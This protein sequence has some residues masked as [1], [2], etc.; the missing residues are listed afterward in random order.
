M[1]HVGKFV[2]IS[3][4]Q[5]HWYWVIIMGLSLLTQCISHAVVLADF[6]ILLSL[7]YLMAAF[8][9]KLGFLQICVKICK[10]PVFYMTLIN[11]N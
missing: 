3:E 7:Y 1:E 2:F 11:G 6:V 4:G 9:L 10:M 8:F 5:L